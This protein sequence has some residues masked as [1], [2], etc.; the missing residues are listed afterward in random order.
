MTRRETER[1]LAAELEAHDNVDIALSEELFKGG[2]PLCRHRVVQGGRF[3]RSLVYE[4]VNDVG[5]RKVLE[6][7]RG[8]CE[9]H[10]VALYE[11]DRDEMGGALGAA[12]LLESVLRHRLAELASAGVEL[13]RINRQ[14]L[15]LAAVAADCPVCA[16]E[17]DGVK[18]AIE[19]LLLRLDNDRWREALAN[20]TLCLADT[21]RLARAAAIDE[22]RLASVQPVLERQLARLS[23]LREALEAF[24]HD[25]T[26]DRQHH[27]T[28]EQHV[29][30]A[31]A[32]EVLGGRE[33][34]EWR[35]GRD[36]VAESD[37]EPSE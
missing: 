22:K 6:R 35:H 25:S 18:Q 4:G 14:R 16:A 17:D 10:T 11:A 12:I 32:T 28:R 30:A 34:W 37:G 26:Y 5:F 21:V 3:L 8:F 9:R 13:N 36:K 29:S 15:D 20:S 7:S 24:A 27:L 23:K 2:C 31:Q 33:G 19:R 1:K